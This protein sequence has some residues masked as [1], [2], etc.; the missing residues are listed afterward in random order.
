M[1][2]F[3]TCSLLASI[4]C[5]RRF[6][7]V[8]RT[9][10]DRVIR[11]GL[12]EAAR[13]IERDRVGPRDWRA[14]P[15]SLTLT[16]TTL[17]PSRRSNE[18]ETCSKSLRRY[19]CSRHSDMKVHVQE[20]SAVGYWVWDVKDEDDICGI[21]QNAFDGVC[22]TCEEPGDQCPLCELINSN[23]EIHCDYLCS[24]CVPFVLTV[25]GTCSHIFHMHCI[26]RWIEKMKNEKTALCPLCKRPW[27]EY[28]SRVHTQLARL[29]QRCPLR[30]SHC[31]GKQGS[32]RVGAVTEE[33]TARK[34][35]RRGQ[36]CRSGNAVSLFRSCMLPAHTPS[37]S[38][39]HR[40]VVPSPYLLVLLT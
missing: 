14:T 3:A 18:G 7:R 19:E 29:T 10:S 11:S 15:G 2:S 23:V 40:E 4:D 26:I 17:L 35:A 38:L 24:A 21:C 28:K 13:Q 31:R 12:V 9:W 39:Y 22:G 32:K 30:G 34:R 25:F 36:Y 8:T 27:R 1:A 20:W 33:Y 16:T 37:P 6:R 5:S